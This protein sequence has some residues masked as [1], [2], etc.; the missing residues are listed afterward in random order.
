MDSFPPHPLKLVPLQGGAD[1]VTGSTG[2]KTS[3]AKQG[4]RRCVGKEQTGE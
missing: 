2:N 1:A 4:G 3:G